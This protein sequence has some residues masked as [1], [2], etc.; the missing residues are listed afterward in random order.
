MWYKCNLQLILVVILFTE[1]SIEHWL[2]KIDR[3]IDIK[4]NISDKHVQ[5]MDKEIER[6]E[7]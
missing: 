5:Y 7:Y 3:E 6:T 4:L 1:K 2:D